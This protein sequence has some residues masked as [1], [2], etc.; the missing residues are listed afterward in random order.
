[1]CQMRAGIKLFFKMCGGKIFK[2]FVSACVSPKLVCV[3]F[4]KNCP[5][6]KSPLVFCLQKVSSYCVTVHEVTVFLRLGITCLYL[7]FPCYNPSRIDWIPATT[8]LFPLPFLI[9]YLRI[10]SFTI[11]LPSPTLPYLQT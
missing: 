8:T 6:N 10:F 1:M 11:I 3:K 2:T 7:H 9:V 4:A 5:L